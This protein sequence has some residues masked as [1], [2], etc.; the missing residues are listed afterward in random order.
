MI[1]KRFNLNKDNLY[2]RSYEEDLEQRGWSVS[3][4]EDQAVLIPII[5]KKIIST[6][7]TIFFVKQIA[8]IVINNKLEVDFKP[9]YW[10]FGISVVTYL[11]LCFKLL[12]SEQKDSISLISAFGILFLIASFII[13]FTLRSEILRDIKK[14]IIKNQY[15]NS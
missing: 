2:F 9:N 14:S 15:E 7:F 8:L 13:F 5:W 1:I 6:W 4:K 10:S 3:V 12:L 11:V